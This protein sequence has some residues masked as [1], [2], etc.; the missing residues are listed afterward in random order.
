MELVDPN[1]LVVEVTSTFKFSPY[2]KY[3]LGGDDE[4]HESTQASSSCVSGPRNVFHIL[5]QL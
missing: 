5:L 2:I 3:Y 4:L 1:L